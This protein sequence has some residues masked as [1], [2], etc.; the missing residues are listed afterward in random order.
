MIDCS[1]TLLGILDFHMVAFQLA[2]FLHVCCKGCQVLS[3]LKIT[4]FEILNLN[5]TYFS[6]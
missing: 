5:C 6:N 3:P 4:L 1:A 2:L